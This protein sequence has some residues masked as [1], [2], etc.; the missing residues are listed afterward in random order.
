MS[1]KQTRV[2]IFGLGPMGQA[3]AGVL[4]DAGHDVT[5]WN[6][7]PAKA[8]PLVARGARRASDPSDAVAGST[9][10]LVSLMDYDAVR[11]V[12]LPVGGALRGKAL[13][14]LTA[15]T[16]QG[17]REMA[18]WA[19]AH[20]IDYL[21]GAI[22]SPADF[23]GGEQAHI[24]YS[25]PEDVYHAHE[26]ILKTLA[27]AQYLG[28]E[29]GH[30]AAHEVALLDMFWS[31]VAGI[32][33]AFA[34]ARTEHVTGRALAPHLKVIAELLPAIVDEF[35][36][37]VDDDK[38]EGDVSNIRSTHAALT[39]IIAA[40][41]AHGIDTGVLAATKALA[42][43]AIEAGHGDDGFARITDTLTPARV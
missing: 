10:V 27:T 14:N 19:G 26:P 8:D 3:I 32:V 40:A 1:M 20:G 31:S 30:A 18:A 29:P 2:T 6:R 43:K 11:D 12:L 38:Y 35:A 42:A 5:V 33:H 41:Q 7:T 13:V 22:L 36:W 9:L 37:R 28:A 15:G 17:A 21:E 25:G 39:H 24:L 4:L 23:M 34:L 16:P